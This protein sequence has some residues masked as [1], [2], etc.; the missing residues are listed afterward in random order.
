MNAPG[1]SVLARLEAIA[2]AEHVLAQPGARE[3][4]A[5][6]GVAPAAVVRP[7]SPEQVAEVVRFAAAEKLAVVPVGGRSKLGIGGPPQRY[8]L[9]LDLTR[10]DQIAHYDPGDLTLSVDAGMPLARLAEKLAAHG[11]FVPL[12]APWFQSATVGGTIASGVDSPLRQFYGTARDFVIGAEFVTGAGALAKSGGRVVKNVTGYDLHKLLIGSLGT[13]AVLTRVNFRTFPLPALSRGFVAA[14]ATA[15]GALELRRRIAASPLTP[16]TLE[17]LSPECARLFAA[18]RPGS[19]AA[20]LAAPG[21]WFHGEQWQVC[22]GF[23]GS[24]AV[25]A[26][27]ARDL[28]RLAGEAGA[29][30]VQIFDEDAQPPVWTRLREGLPLLLEASPAAAIFKL[31]LLPGQFAAV[32]E[33]LRAAAE[34]HALAC[35]L[36]ARGCGAVYFALLPER[37][38][39]AALARLAAAAATIFEIAAAGGGHA[40]LLFCPAALKRS[41][42]V[43]GPPRAEFALLPRVKSAFDPA[44]ILAPGRFAGGV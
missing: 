3:A 40:A 23:E 15:Q 7:A 25:V 4:C 26:R 35:A 30:G 38:D 32:F 42:S 41:V 36:L 24:E 18:N 29:A 5:V 8:D 11:Q 16:V 9:A 37:N 10:L 21:A 14:F 17:I 39:A 31:S 12:G 34:R 1:S 2:G 19:L 43:W 20:P 44:G 33:A 6:D 27:Y 22:A 28:T 13:L